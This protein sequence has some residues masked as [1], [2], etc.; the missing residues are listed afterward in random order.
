M[1]SLWAFLIS[2]I[3]LGSVGIIGFLAGTSRRSQL[4]GLFFW[5]FLG[6]FIASAIL[7][8]I[9]AARL[10]VNMDKQCNN[11]GFARDTDGCRNIREY[12][13]FFSLPLSFFSPLLLLFLL[14]FLSPL[15]FPF[16]LLYFTPPPPPPLYL[17]YDGLLDIITYTAFGAFFGTW[18]PTFLLASAYFWRITRLYR[19]E[20]YEGA[21]HDAYGNR[22]PVG[23][24]AL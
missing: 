2:G 6:G 3:I 5:A 15:P 13:I 11:N 7:L 17:F 9:N 10:D 20:P 21:R 24:P 23:Q 19:K 4:A 22:Y 14:P 1:N 8:I 12:R 18:V 16:S